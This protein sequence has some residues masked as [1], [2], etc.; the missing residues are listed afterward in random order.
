MLYTSKV[1]YFQ[2]E[3]I[4]LGVIASFYVTGG[5]AVNKQ[6]ANRILYILVWSMNIA[7]MW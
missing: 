2:I 1:L 7:A 5:N 6:Y 3:E 4:F